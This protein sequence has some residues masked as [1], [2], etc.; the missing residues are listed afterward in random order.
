MLCVSGVVAWQLFLKGPWEQI[1]IRWEQYQ[2]RRREERARERLFAELQPVKLANCEFKRFGEPNDGGYLL[3]ANLLASVQ[4]GYSYGISGYDQW[5]CDVS[6]GLTVPVHEY[7]CFN[8]QVPVC[9][10][11]RTVFHGECIGAEPATIE[12]RPFDTLE[13]QFAKNGDGAKRVVVKMDVEGAEWDSLLRTPDD[14]LQRIDQLTIELHGV[15]EPERFIAVVMKLKKFF[16][17]A[18]IHFNNFA[19]EEGIAPFPAEVYEVLFV[20]KRRGRARRVG[21]GRRS[22]RRDGT[23][24]YA[25]EGL[26]VSCGSSS[27][28]SSGSVGAEVPVSGRPL[29]AREPDVQRHTS[30][31]HNQARSGRTRDRD[32]GRSRRW[33]G[34]QG[35]RSPG[36]QDSPT[37]RN[38]RGADGSRNRSTKSAATATPEKSTTAK[39]VYRVSASALPDSTS[40]PLQIACATIATAGVR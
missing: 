13:N 11:G 28:S 4:S 15:R 40:K 27:G 34:W 3:C 1:Q 16:Y 7:D 37:A 2:T 18:N 30:R 35:R 39:P 33:P 6:R 5:G 17:V 36:P 10:L 14:V 26:P 21:A 20:S 23:Q 8:L 9:P 32:R 24:H 38:G 29:A 22:P 25:V 31:N 12:G 19:C